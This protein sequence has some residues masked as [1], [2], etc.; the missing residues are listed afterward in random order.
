MRQTHEKMAHLSEFQ[1]ELCRLKI[2]ID[3]FITTLEG[4]V[5]PYEN[6]NKI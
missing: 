5:V 6:Y 3:L 4:G 1:T 2:C